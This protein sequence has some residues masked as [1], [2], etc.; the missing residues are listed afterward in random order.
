MAKGHKSPGMGRPKKNI[1]PEV[2]EKLA[3]IMCT[4][5]E[6]ATF[7]DCS[8]DTLERRFADIIKRGQEKAED[9]SSLW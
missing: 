4:M 7:V 6:I 8:V 1:D 9:L 2:V 5:N 3:S